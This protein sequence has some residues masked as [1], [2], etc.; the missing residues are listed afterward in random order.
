VRVSNNTQR[1]KSIE[2]VLDKPW[3]LTVVWEDGGSETLGMQSRACLEREGVAQ[4]LVDSP[5]PLAL[6]FLLLVNALALH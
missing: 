2:P 3:P 6:T 4:L 1:Q 5:F